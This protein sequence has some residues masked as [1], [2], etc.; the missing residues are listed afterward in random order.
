MRED[1]TRVDRGVRVKPILYLDVDGVISPHGR[2]VWLDSVAVRLENSYGV[3]YTVRLSRSMGQSIAG[4]GVEIR[5]A[6][7]WGHDAPK[8][9]APLIGL[10][11]GSAVTSKPGADPPLLGDQGFS[12][13]KGADIRREVELEGRPFIWVDDDSITELD[14][15]W[16]ANLQVDCL[17]IQPDAYL[18]L[19]PKHLVQMR[20]F[21]EECG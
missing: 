2:S 18:G 19:E 12:L 5:W 3:S 21:I 7:S 8:L 1:D 13:F 14:R 15:L 10:P 16:A 17:L 20:G 6:T 4:L 11:S 9:I